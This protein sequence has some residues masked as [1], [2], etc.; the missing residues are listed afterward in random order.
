MNAVRVGAVLAWL[1]SLACSLVGAQELFELAVPGSAVR[2]QAELTAEALI[3]R[4]AE[5]NVF[6]YAR[7]PG[8]DA[9][10]GSFVGF[11]NADLGKI[12][13]WPARGQGAMQ[14]GERAAGQVVFR[15]SQMRVHRRDAP[16]APANLP[17]G[18]GPA[19]APR[20]MVAGP[21]Y[22]ATTGRREG[23]L[24]GGYVGLEGRLHFAVER[25]G[26]W[27]LRTVEDHPPFPPGAP[28]VL[29]EDSASRL[30]QALLVDDTGRL[31]A[32]STVGARNLT[33]A[34]YRVGSHLAV[35]E[36]DG[37]RLLFSVDRDGRLSELPLDP[38]ARATAIEAAVD[39]LLPGSPLAAA[40]GDEVL[41]VDARGRLRRYETR[42]GW[43]RADPRDAKG[44]P[45][46]LTFMP[47][48][49]LDAA[50]VVPPGGTF[51]TTHVALTD[52]YGRVRIVYETAVPRVWAQ[53]T[54]ADAWLHPGAPVALSAATRGLVL[55][56]IAADGVWQTW[57]APHAGASWTRLVITQGMRPF[58]PVALHG[59]G[60][61]GFA[62]DP[63]GS[64][65][66]A[67]YASSGAWHTHLCAPRFALA[68][69][70]VSREVLANAPL[71][72]AR[73]ELVN[74]HQLE[75][76][77]LIA[78]VRFPQQS[79][80]LKILPGESKTVEL[81]RDAGGRVVETFAVPSPL[82]IVEEQQTFVLPPETLYDISVYELFLQ[83]I[84]I[85]RT[86][87]GAGAIEDENWSPK[88]IGVFPIP[89]GEQ[90]RDGDV[91]DVFDAAR[92]QQNPGAVR[93]L[94]LQEWK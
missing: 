44:Q 45:L 84:A 55:S 90:L 80:R 93:R 24:F 9:S 18:R 1:P 6:R 76:W 69:Q 48:S 87:R 34:R 51:P 49:R 78:D 7:A 29:L 36:R 33:A 10:D 31:T 47:G 17:A 67:R 57:H 30:P 5:G 22:V 73:V 25:N 81:A 59:A 39:E 41:L 46:R 94:D 77:V 88:S 2:S 20:T 14:L 27:E 60:R 4:D 35:A 61:Y 12:I 58:G 15:E 83:S 63:R 21:T 72:P 53:H 32:V 26:E 89:P 68:P 28:L 37:R 43:T 64:L 70:L 11:T 86:K 82:G 56:A 79:S 13:R 23:S 66:V 38:V 42:A 52:A 16:V 62:V 40:T 50:R 92:R 74:R 85:D 91:I 54:L 65:L 19:V 3:I 8:Y 75:L 71:A